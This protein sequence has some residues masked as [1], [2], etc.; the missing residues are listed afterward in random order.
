MSVD[1]RV[2]QGV[3]GHSTLAWGSFHVDCRQNEDERKMKRWGLD[4]PDLKRSNHSR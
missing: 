3:D 2:E 1:R 4:M